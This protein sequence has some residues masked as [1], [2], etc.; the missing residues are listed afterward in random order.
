VKDKPARKK[1]TYKGEVYISGSGSSGHQIYQKA[2]LQNLLSGLCVDIKITKIKH[3]VRDKNPRICFKMIYPD[4]GEVDSRFQIADVKHRRISSRFLPAVLRE[5]SDTMAQQ[6]EQV[7][8]YH[9]A[10]A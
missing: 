9:R 6:V 5:G 4:P 1:I 10:F 7:D 8:G 3:L 2:G